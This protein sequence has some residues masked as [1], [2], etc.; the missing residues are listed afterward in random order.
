MSPA[1]HSNR[2]RAG[3]SLVET[4]CSITV[5]VVAVTG[6]SAYSYKASLDSRK[7][8][9]RMTATRHAMLMCESWRGVGGDATFD[10]AT[11]FGSDL[12]IST[13]SQWDGT[14][15]VV[16][17]FTPLGTYAVDSDGLPWNAGVRIK[18]LNLHAC[19]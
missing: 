4:M 13:P 15:F 14:H 8:Q 3:M 12:N 7:A 11:Y 6:T 18:S 5:L 17:G 16:S 19:R 2:L 10:P 9:M 1:P